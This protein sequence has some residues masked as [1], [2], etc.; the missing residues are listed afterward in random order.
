MFVFN[1]DRGLIG[2]DYRRNNGNYMFCRVG[3]Q[4]HGRIGH[5]FPAS[6]PHSALI[7]VCVGPWDLWLSD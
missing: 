1:L 2:L 7:T 3:G 5:R 6:G 4:G